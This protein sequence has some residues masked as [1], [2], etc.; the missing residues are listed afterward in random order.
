MSTS[1]GPAL[2]FADT[3]ADLIAKTFRVAKPDVEI[4]PKVNLCRAYLRSRRVV[5]GRSFLEALNRFQTVP[6]SIP[7]QCKSLIGK[8]LK[9]F[10][11]VE[12]SREEHEK[13]LESLGNC[14]KTVMTIAETIENVGLT[15]GRFVT[16]VCIYSI[17]PE[18][19]SK[20]L[21][22]KK[23]E[24]GLYRRIPEWINEV[25]KVIKVN[26]D[27]DIDYI[28]AA[29]ETVA[30]ASMNIGSTLTMLIFADAFEAEPDTVLACMHS[31][32][33][34][35]LAGILAEYYNSNVYRR[36][37][38]DLVKGTIVRPLEDVALTIE[39]ILFSSYIDLGYEI[40]EVRHDRKR[41]VARLRRKVEGPLSSADLGVVMEFYDVCSAICN[42]FVRSLRVNVSPLL[43]AITKLKS[44]VEMIFSEDKNALK[45]LS[46]RRR[47]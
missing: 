42:T 38:A 10:A 2:I 4:R 3:V 39:R 15:L 32:K 31:R 26:Y 37:L 17:C 25:S 19:Y 28:I 30:E 36:V 14:Q 22:C 40:E 13:L 24:E 41:D 47:W 16:A 6:L 35:E 34:E 5:L 7:E 1:P 9:S 23:R 21:G 8:Y 45:V 11:N 33:F 44:T 27:I 46:R 29:F 18:I 12:M 20:L 43:Y